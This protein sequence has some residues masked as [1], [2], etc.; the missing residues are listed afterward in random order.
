MTINYH[1]EISLITGYLLVICGVLFF[2]WSIRMIFLSLVMDYFAFLVFYVFVF[3]KYSKEKNKGHTLYNLIMAGIILG[4]F[5]G[6]IILLMGEFMDP[7]SNR[8][9]SQFAWL[10]NGFYLFISALIIR[11]V[12]V[13]RKQINQDNLSY[14]R[15]YF[16]KLAFVLSVTAGLG[17]L[18]FQF[19]GKDH[20]FFALISIFILRSVSEIWMHRYQS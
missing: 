17:F 9:N 19:F 13:F 7:D 12:P 10:S 6:V 20:Y 11:F 1:K 4:L 15:D 3:A 8:Q 16:F 2:D 18:V 5:Q 14:Q